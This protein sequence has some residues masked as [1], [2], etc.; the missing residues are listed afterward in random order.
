MKR[1]DASSVIS[2]VINVRRVPELPEVASTI[3]EDGR[4]RAATE[5]VCY[6][7][8]RFRE[9]HRLF[10]ITPEHKG[11]RLIA[12]AFI[13][14]FRNVIHFFYAEAEKRKDDI[15]A[16]DFTTPGS[17]NPAKPSWFDSERQRCHKLMAHLTYSRI[18]LKDG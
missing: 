6:E 12:E 2:T 1:N 17:W 16:T 15:G 8:H 3:P 14:H 11:K 18:T 10:P 7:I 4:L 5:H 13:L 9:A